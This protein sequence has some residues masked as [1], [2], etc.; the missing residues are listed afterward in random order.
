MPYPQLTRQK[1]AKTGDILREA[2]GPGEA[3]RLVR[4]CRI[5]SAIAVLGGVVLGRGWCGAARS[6]DAAL[7]WTAASFLREFSRIAKLLHYRNQ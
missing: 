3:E 1:Q 2:A 6:D 4:A 5:V 7:L